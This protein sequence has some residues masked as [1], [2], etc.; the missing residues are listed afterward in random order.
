MM[1]S[2]WG[3]KART[4]TYRLAASYAIFASV[5]SLGG[6]PSVGRH[7]WNSVMGRASRHTG[8]SSRPSI[9]GGCA[10]RVAVMFDREGVG[11]VG[12]AGRE[13]AAWATSVTAAAARTSNPMTMKRLGVGYPLDDG[14]PQ[15]VVS[16]H[17]DLLPRQLPHH[18]RERAHL[19]AVGR[20]GGITVELR[21]ERPQRRP[22][23]PPRARSP[24][25]VRQG[26][27]HRTD[28]I[29]RQA[30]RALE[31]IEVGARYDKA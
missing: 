2:G 10:A 21:G 9:T 13:S 14:N 30:V 5:G 18:A 8:S 11:G 1:L 19:G 7:S 28:T 20:A 12:R 16:E 15:K 25:R 23:P 3:S 31:L 17:P 26:R 24:F 6:A 4:K 27:P 22:A 29:G